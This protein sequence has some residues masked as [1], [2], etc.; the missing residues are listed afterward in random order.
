MLTSTII[1]TGE[2]WNDIYTD[3][4]RAAGA[5]T[6]FFF[7]VLIATANYM[8]LN[9]VVALLLGSFQVATGT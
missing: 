9:L 6:I 4:H 7:V 5:V 2:G 1:A 8:L 3:V